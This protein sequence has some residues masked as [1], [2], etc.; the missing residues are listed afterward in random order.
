LRA[1]RL[2]SG[3]LGL[4]FG[5]LMSVLSNWLFG[6]GRT[7]LPWLIG[8]FL[9]ACLLTAVY[10][11]R[12]PP[13]SWEAELKAP[14]QLTTPVERSLHARR[15]LIAFVPLYRPGRGSRA[16]SLKPEEWLARA[17][18]LDFT[19]LDPEH[20]NFAPTV[21]AI[22]AHAEHLEECWLLTT[23]GSESGGSQPYAAVLAEY[24]RINRTMGCR[25]HFDQPGENR[26]TIPLEDDSQVVRRTYDLV[27]SVFAEAADSEIE[28]REVVADFSTGQR[29]MMLGM[30]LACLDRD[31]D[32]EF[33]GTDYDTTG[34]P[35]EGRLYPIIY[36][37]QPA[38][39]P[40]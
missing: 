39:P 20:S 31:R 7:L 33:V 10:F 36:G 21:A 13:P 16:A 18:Q 15:G 14:V 8:F 4:V 22:M 1:Q 26:Y 9:V 6:E 19:A 11:L 37:F 5:V 30:V 24:L 40:D 2:A 29:S 12:Q 34:Q 35:I 17:G 23:S 32:L 27:R 38:A 3:L 28:A 25:F